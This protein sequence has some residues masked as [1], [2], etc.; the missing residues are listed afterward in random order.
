M[1]LTVNLLVDWHRLFVRPDR[2]LKLA[3]VVQQYREVIETL[4]DRRMALAI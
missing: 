4:R 3:R 2:R 1:L